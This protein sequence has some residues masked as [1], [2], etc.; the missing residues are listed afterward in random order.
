MYQEL[1]N[2]SV[3]YNMSVLWKEKSLVAWWLRDQTQIL[4]LNIN[5]ETKRYNV[6]HN[7]ASR[8]CNSSLSNVLGLNTLIPFGSIHRNHRVTFLVKVYITPVTLTVPHH[9]LST[10]GLFCFHFPMFCMGN[11]WFNIMYGY[12]DIHL[13]CIVNIWFNVMHE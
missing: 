2:M 10:L 7:V 3:G 12:T 6:E 5:H 1:V 4:K 11:V 8:N 13:L 9:N